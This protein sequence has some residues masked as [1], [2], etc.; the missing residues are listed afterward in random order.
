MKP[1]RIILIAKAIFLSLVYILLVIGV[2]VAIA[3][4]SG[5]DI[6]L[7]SVTL[8]IATSAILLHFMDEEN[9]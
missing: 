9:Q 7:E 1:F 5:D 4:L 6:T 3:K 2:Y 8:T